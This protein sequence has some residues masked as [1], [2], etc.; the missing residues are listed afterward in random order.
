MHVLL[1]VFPLT[2]NMLL[3]FQSGKMQ[4]CIDITLL[5]EPMLVYATNKHSRKEVVN[6]RSLNMK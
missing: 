1:E 4:A 2:H 5:H 6:H 3:S